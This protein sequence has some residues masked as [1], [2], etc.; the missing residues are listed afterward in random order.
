MIAFSFPA[1]AQTWNTSG[2]NSG[3]S[4]KL[5]VFDPGEGID[6]TTQS[7]TRMSLTSS[8]WLGVGITAPRG[9]QELNYC[10]G[11][12]NAENGLIVTLNKC[13][14]NVAR[15]L[16]DNDVIGFGL[17]GDIYEIPTFTPPLSYL[18]GSNTNIITPLYGTVSAK[19][20]PL[21]WLRVQSPSGFWTTSGPDE[22]DTKFIVM[23]DG[24]CGIN[25]AKP[26]A[27]LDVRGSNG[28]NY[29][30]AIIGAR[31][32]GYNVVNGGLTQ[33][34]TQQVQFVPRLK[35]D[36]YNQ[37]V[38]L[39]DQGMFFTDGKGENTNLTTPDKHD[40]SNEN[41]AFVLAPWAASANSDIGGMRMAANGDTEFHGTLRATK[42]N[43][44]AKWW[45]DFVFDED[46]ELKSLAEVEAYIVANKHLPDVPS[47]EEVLANGLDLGEMQA[48]QQQKIEELTLYIIQQQKQMD[49]LLMMIT[50]LKK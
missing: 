35:A 17:P 24:S 28:D 47:E 38:Q 5:G 22:F 25:I 11:V 13:N 12:G 43:V 18:T 23:P 40:G 7:Q 30:A 31:S 14:G 41:G 20:S 33:F 42:V 9:W 36:G 37:I 49:A 19:N 32:L 6:F 39:G 29:P 27:A 48:I 1:F 8:G 4:L 21:F 3:A 44:D 34:Y 45:S 50:E 26:R 10:P 46:Y 16:G 2:N 15:D